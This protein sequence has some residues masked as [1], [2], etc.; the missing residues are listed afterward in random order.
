MR[1][2]TFAR[3]PHTDA[4]VQTASQRPASMSPKRSG[5][6]RVLSELQKS[7]RQSKQ[8]KVELAKDLGAWTA[9][10][11]MVEVLGKHLGKL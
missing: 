5:S 10:S 4:A 6:K 8:S 9:R 11:Y 2:F 1:C 3:R 7:I